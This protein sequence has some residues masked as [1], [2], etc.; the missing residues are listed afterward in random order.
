MALWE[1]DIGCLSKREVVPPCECSRQQFPRGKVLQFPK[2]GAEAHEVEDIGTVAEDDVPSLEDKV[3]DSE[4]AGILAL[5]RYVSC[6][7]CKSKW[8][9]RVM[10]SVHAQDV[11][12]CRNFS[13]AQ[14]RREP[15]WYSHFRE[16][17]M[18]STFGKHL[19][20]IAGS[21][22]SLN[23]IYLPQSLFPSHMQTI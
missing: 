18:P 5:D 17:D 4:V 22:K 3:H 19:E 23:T 13:N 20:E 21:G 8:T 11:A 14:I 9:R 1:N 12:W 6:L 7:S 2:G 15:D 16:V 10:C